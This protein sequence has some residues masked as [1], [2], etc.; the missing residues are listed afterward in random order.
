MIADVINRRWLL[1]LLTGFMFS[2]LAALAATQAQAATEGE[3]AEAFIKNL[4][5]SGIAM[6]ED[7]NYTGA[8]RELQFRNLVK[9]G[10]ALEAIGKFVVGRYWREMSKDQQSEYLELFSEWVLTT[11]ANRL[12]GYSGQTLEI[13]KSVETDS[14]Y[15]DVIVSTRVN[16]TNGQPPINADWRVRKFGS[17]YKIIDISVEGASMVGTQR[18]EFEAVIRKVGVEG[19]VNELRDRLAVL[20]A[21]GG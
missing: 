13:V 5:V 11:Y 6:L 7:G 10:F 4:A 2:I 16:L 1:G 17:D 21:N 19:L 9:K 20:V 15:K 3:Q 18:R 14:R 8:E 12:G